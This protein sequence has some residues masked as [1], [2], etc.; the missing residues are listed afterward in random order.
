MK[1]MIIF[2]IPKSQAATFMATVIVTASNN[3]AT[4]RKLIAC[5]MSH[6]I[7]DD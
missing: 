7:G 3:R 1:Y 4:D 2:L 6:A 5:H